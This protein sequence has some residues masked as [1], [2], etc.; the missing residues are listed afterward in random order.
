MYFRHL[1]ILKRCYCKCLAVYLGGRTST[2]TAAQ[3][4][5]SKHKRRHAR[6]VSV[7]STKTFSFGSCESEAIAHRLSRTLSTHAPPGIS[8][9]EQHRPRSRKPRQRSLGIHLLVALH[10]FCNLSMRLAIFLSSS[11]SPVLYA[12][13]SLT[14]ADIP[15]K[16]MGTTVWSRYARMGSDWTFRRSCSVSAAFCSV[17]STSATVTDGGPCG[18]TRFKLA[19]DDGAVDGRISVANRTVPRR[20]SRK[21][22]R[23]DV[24]SSWG[25]G[26]G[27]RSAELSSQPRTYRRWSGRYVT[28]NQPP[29]S[30]LPSR[31]K[32]E[33]RNE[34]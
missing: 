3:S 20:S 9:E 4:V 30:T 31:G 29:G 27:K 6:C 26:G 21:E 25:G 23:W 8:Y 1:L 24:L 2:V 13:R 5:A 17:D 18:G 28:A 19:S 14:R 10:T 11:P 12:H 22:G 15:S 16:R 32:S 33:L 34:R 7:G